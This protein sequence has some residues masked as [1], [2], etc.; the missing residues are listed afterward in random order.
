MRR[1]SVALVTTA[2]RQVN[3]LALKTHG[4]PNT[5]RRVRLPA[6][7]L[8]LVAVASCAA[9]GK[10]N[11]AAADSDYKDIVRTFD[12]SEPPPE[13]RKPVE[14]SGLADLL[15]PD[16]ARFERLIDK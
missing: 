7:A 9:C 5:T 1:H 12:D 8:L 13:Q 16:K 6:L 15:E 2:T 3:R 11:G 14:A 10:K 4:V